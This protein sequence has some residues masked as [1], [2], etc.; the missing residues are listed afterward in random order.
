MTTDTVDKQARAERGGYRVGG[1][2]KGVGMISPNLAT[3]LVFLTTDAPV[4]PAAVHE[5]ALS[6]LEEPFESLTVDASTSTNDTILLLA[7]RCGRRRPVTPASSGWSH[8]SAAIADVAESLSLS[9][10]RRRVTHVVLVDVEGAATTADARIV[11]KSVADSPLVKTAVFGG[12]PNPGRIL[13][14]VGSSGA[15]FDPEDVDGWIGDVPVIVGG[16]IARS[17]FDGDGEVARI[18]MRSPRSGSVSPRRRARTEPRRAATCPTVRAHQWGV[19]D[20]TDRAPPQ[21]Q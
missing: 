14:A 2:A 20:V 11:A 1:A 4:P 12:D 7:K 19:H 6:T 21:I 9:S 5:L 3:M 10:S 18:A 13:Q 16:H 8:L 17:Y 15:A